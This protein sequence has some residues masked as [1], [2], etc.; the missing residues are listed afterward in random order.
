MTLRRTFLG[1]ILTGTL[2]VAADQGLLNLVMRDPSVIA[3]IDLDRARNSPIGQK[4]LADMKDDDKKLQQLMAD[5]GFDPRRDLR[6]AIVV[7]AAPGKHDQGLVLARG[8]FDP[9]KI[10]TFAKTQGA[11]S[12]LYRGLEI[13]KGGEK[14]GDGGFAFLDNSIAIL[15]TEAQVMA[16]IDRKLDGKGG[17]SPALAAKVALWSGA[18]DAWIISNEPIAGFGPFPNKGGSPQGL[19]VD[20]VMAANAGVRFGSLIEISAETTMR[21]DKDATALADVIRFLAS[22][23]R[24]NQNDKNKPPEAVLSMLDSMQLDVAGNLVKVRLTLPQADLEKMMLNGPHSRKRPV[25]KVI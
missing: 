7:S 17:L 22:M 12:S 4:I 5:T 2:A 24:M 10:A 3:G 1:L 20:S 18:N 11:V 21:S 15:G 23:V 9:G 16:A 8:T 6:E 25:A 13:W 19:S 14:G